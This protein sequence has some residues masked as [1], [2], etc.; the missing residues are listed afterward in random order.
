MNGTEA[1]FPVPPANWTFPPEPPLFNT[2]HKV[3]TAFVILPVLLVWFLVWRYA[4]KRQ[5]QLNDPAERMRLVYAAV[6]GSMT[7][8]LAGHALPNALIGHA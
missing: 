7:G 2:G 4:V 3:A 1:P 5:F 8:F 6:A